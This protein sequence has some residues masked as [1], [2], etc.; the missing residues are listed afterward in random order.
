[1][2][3]LLTGRHEKFAGK[4]KNRPILRRLQF[5]RIYDKNIDRTHLSG[6]ENTASLTLCRGIF[7]A[8]VL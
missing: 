8:G 2:A 4:R 7:R 1:M 3:F 6:T 5:L